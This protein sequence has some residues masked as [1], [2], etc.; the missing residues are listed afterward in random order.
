MSIFGKSGNQPTTLSKDFSRSPRAEIQRSVFNRDHGLKT[1]IDAGKL[2]PIFYDEALPGDT[3]E[4]DANGFGRLATPI[5]PYMDNLTSKHFFSV[6]HLELY[7]ITG[8]SFVANKLILEIVQT[9]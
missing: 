5:N 2:Y 3:F 7:G 9:I 8:K 4:L 1:T 6:S